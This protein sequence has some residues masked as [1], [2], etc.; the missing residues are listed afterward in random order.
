[1]VDL[2]ASPPS[3]PRAA[4]RGRGPARRR[5]RGPRTG[6]PGRRH[7]DG[8]ARPHRGRRCRRPRRRVHRQRRHR[9]HRAHAARA[10]RLRPHRRR[11]AVARRPVRHRRRR[12]PARGRLAGPVRRGLLPGDGFDDPTA[13]SAGSATSAASTTC[14]SRTSLT[15]EVVGHVAAAGRAVPPPRLDDARRGRD[16][17]VRAGRAGATRPARPPR[18]ARRT[19]HRQDRRRP[20]PRRVARLQRPAH[21]RRPHPGARP[22]RPV[23]AVRADGAADARRGPHHADDVRSPPRRP[24]SAVG[25]DERWIDLLDRFEASLARRR[26]VQGRVAHDARG[27]RRASWSSGSA[28]RRCRGGIAARSSCSSL[29]RARLRGAATAEVAKAVARRLAVVHARTRRGAK[30]RTPRTP[31]RR[32]APTTSFIDAWL[33]GR[34]RRCAAR[35][36]AGPL[37]GRARPVLATSSSTRPRT[38][39]CSSCGRCM[40]RADGLTLVGDDAQRS[41]PGQHRPARRGPAARRRPRADDDRVPHVGRD[42]RVAQRPRRRPRPSTRVDPGR[43][44]PHRRR[45]SPSVD[46]PTP[47]TPCAPTSPTAGRNVADHPRR[48]GL[49]PQGRRVRRGRGRRRAP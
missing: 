43:H 2:P 25:G 41:N 30:L 21:H 10:R 15:G 49:G 28:T 26:A 45:R 31:R 39:R 6:P 17:A 32:S 19:G 35:R 4:D 20:P 23:P 16:A 9:R 40:R 12:R 24:A 33:D 1:M 13:S 42:R 5:A 22:E 7:Q 18:A 11:P 46:R 37:R 48:R 8:Q 36:G 3:S 38:S 44:P 34:R 29:A 47:P 27:R 14:W